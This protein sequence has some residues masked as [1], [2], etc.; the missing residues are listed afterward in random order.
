MAKY[1]A[2]ESIHVGTGVET[3]FGFTWP[4]LIASDV[5]ITLNGAP[6]PTVL[7]SPNQI[8]INPAPAAGA[9]IRI[10][11]DTPAQA[12]AYLFAGGI[13]FLPRYVDANNK[14]LLYALQEGLLAFEAVDAVADAALD[15]AK[16][17]EVAAALAL[18][19]STR[20][21]RVPDTDAPIPPLADA[22]SRAGK[23]LGFNHAGDPVGT[24]PGTGTA[25]ELAIDLAD[26]ALPGRGDAMIGVRAAGTTAVG[27]T[28][29]SK[30]ADVVSA[31]DYCTDAV[32]VNQ[33]TAFRN[34]E[35]VHAGRVVDLAGKTYLVDALPTG[36]TY[37]NGSFQY[38]AAGPFPYLHGTVVPGDDS[39]GMISGLTSTGGAGAPYR[40]GVHNTP[41]VAG[42]STRWRRVIVGSQGCRAD[43]NISGCYSS[44]YCWAY[45]N[46]S[47]NLFS[48]QSVAGCP[49]GVNIAS[50]E[51]QVYG[52]GG[53]NANTHFSITNGIKPT[54]LSTRLSYAGAARYCVNI[55][56]NTSRV[57]GGYGA[58]LDIV[59]DGDKVLRVDIIDGGRAFDLDHRMY[60]AARQRAPTVEAVLSF[61]VDAT[62]T[63]TTVTVVSPGAGYITGDG[64][65]VCVEYPTEK[66]GECA[67]NYSTFQTRTNGKAA[68]SIATNEGINSGNFSS[69]LATNSCTTTRDV[70]WQFIAASTASHTVG[71][72]SAV[73][74]GNQARANHD[75]SLVIGRRVWSAESRTF[76]IGGH[77]SVAGTAARKFQVRTETGTTDV[78]S[79]VNINQVF[80][81]IAKMFENRDGAIPVASMVAW[82]GRKVRLAQAGDTDVSVHSRTYA[83]LLGDSGLEWSNRYETDE[84]G[85]KILTPTWD[86]DTSE[87]RMLPAESA[88]FDP[89]LHQIPRSA[90][91][92][93]WTPV[94]LTGEVHIRV[95]ADVVPNGYIKAADGGMG[96][97]A[98]GQTRIRCMAITQPFDPAKGYA[99]ALGLI[100]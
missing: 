96:T 71:T 98:T 42:R 29:H 11:R 3:V 46:V 82:D 68:S 27:R 83:I 97:L 23:I 22:A 33:T 91:R 18:A 90:R 78:A 6:V 73:L 75:Y 13:P 7:V 95:T 94:A 86:E 93:E 45:G 92:D 43:F 60:I 80:T 36:N 49:Q 88:D 14:Q 85:E 39:P 1:N 76:V 24:L 40:G 37:T 55:A 34:L 81:D 25:T 65:D 57:G 10:Y 53:L 58:K 59:F 21:L 35:V 70:A 67:G 8:A 52:F 56:S 31:L 89:T 61:T 66:W 77:P 100:R 62:G 63:I 32:G 12:P 47:G 50:E 16:A 20:A 79:S 28:Q 15:A 5:Y 4:A 69:L 2:P 48:R 44:I 38:S 84:F 41:T 99:V 74:C 54:N 87:Y 26:S 19:R 51:G 17:A 30:N 72:G 9:I 64:F